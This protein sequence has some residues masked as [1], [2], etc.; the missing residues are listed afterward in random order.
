[1]QRIDEPESGTAG[2]DRRPISLC[3]SAAGRRITQYGIETLPVVLLLFCGRRGGGGGTPIPGP[4]APIC[5]GADEDLIGH[6]AGDRT[7][8]TGYLGTA[9]ASSAALSLGADQRSS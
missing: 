8:G 7:A 9:A 5:A 1:M 2:A 4:A 3:A 6:A